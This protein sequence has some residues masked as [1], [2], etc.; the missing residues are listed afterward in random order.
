MMDEE[1]VLGMEVN[2]MSRAQLIEMLEKLRENRKKGY[3]KSAKTRRAS[4]P[5]N[6]IPEDI[7]NKILDELKKK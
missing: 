5:F 2:E 7:A 6:D 4:N 3:E 1:N